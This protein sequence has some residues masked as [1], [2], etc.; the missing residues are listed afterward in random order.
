MQIS[1][2]TL[3]TIILFVVVAAFVTFVASIDVHA[4]VAP[5]V[6]VE[7]VTADVVALVAA[8]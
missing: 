1:T 4:P 2:H 3:I 8:W 6:D 5:F 7:V